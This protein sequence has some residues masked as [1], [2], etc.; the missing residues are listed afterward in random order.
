MSVHDALWIISCGKLVKL[1][2][3]WH[4]STIPGPG[5]NKAL[6]LYTEGA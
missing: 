3:N 6:R 5:L 2:T 1:N 4:N